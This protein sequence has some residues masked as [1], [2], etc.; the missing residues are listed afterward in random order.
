MSNSNNFCLNFYT[1]NK[2]PGLEKASRYINLHVTQK[3]PF[4]WI[5]EINTKEQIFV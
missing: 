2:A 1:K 4:Y 3:D 5:C